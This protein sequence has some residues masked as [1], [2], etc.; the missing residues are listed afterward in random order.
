M[1]ALLM[2]A[3]LKEA[4]RHAGRHAA[5]VLRQA[6]K[7]G[8]HSKKVILITNAWT[9]WAHSRQTW[10]PALSICPIWS[11]AS[12]PVESRPNTIGPKSRNSWKVPREPWH[13]WES[14]DAKPAVLIWNKTAALVLFQECLN[15]PPASARVQRT[16]GWRQTGREQREWVLMGTGQMGEEGFNTLHSGADDETQLSGMFGNGFSGCV[17]QL[18]PWA[19]FM[20]ERTGHRTV[21]DTVKLCPAQSWWWKKSSREIYLQCCASSRP[22]AAWAHP[23]LA[24]RIN[25]GGS[26]REMKG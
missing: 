3:W 21:P 13:D 23:H 6:A 9:S 1:G 18:A 16:E 7:L 24:P 10:D 5:C 25:Y 2:C 19:P 14:F 20:Q 4:G 12:R 22:S 8:Q 11:D 15:P 26:Q 17:G